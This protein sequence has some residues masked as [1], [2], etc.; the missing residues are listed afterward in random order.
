MLCPRLSP[1]GDDPAVRELTAPAKSK[2]IAGEAITPP[3]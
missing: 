2:S 1:A 3:W